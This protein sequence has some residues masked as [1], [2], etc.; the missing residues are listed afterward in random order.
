MEPTEQSLLYNRSSLNKLYNT[1]NISSSSTNAS[2]SLVPHQPHIMSHLQC[3]SYPAATFLSPYN[4]ILHTQYHT[5]LV[6]KRFQQFNG[7]MRLQSPFSQSVPPY[8]INNNI[9]INNNSN[10]N[11][12]TKKKNHVYLQKQGLYHYIIIFDVYIVLNNFI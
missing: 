6:H 8:S 9:I 12:Q 11:H 10:H 3:V 7:L 2:Y 4:T 1:S 5:H